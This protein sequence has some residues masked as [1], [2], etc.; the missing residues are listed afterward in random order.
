[1]TTTATR[2]A[3]VRTVAPLIWALVVTWFA[4]HQ[5]D[6]P[7]AIVEAVGWSW[8]NAPMVS[9]AGT[10]L[11]AL[12]LW[13]AAARWPSALEGILLWSRV[14]QRIYEVQGHLV[15]DNP[16]GAPAHLPAVVAGH[17]NQAAG[18][19]LMDA[20]L[21]RRPGPIEARHLA[22]QLLEYANAREA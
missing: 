5:L 22:T 13:V 11:V 19:V 17:D 4:D 18:Q 8:L 14:D 21:T 3:F 6:L 7:A 2:I 12:A 1:M 9:S 16:V 10:I 15:A 20:W